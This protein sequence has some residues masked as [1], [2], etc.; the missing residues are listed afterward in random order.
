MIFTRTNRYTKITFENNENVAFIKKYEEKLGKFTGVREPGYEKSR[1][2]KSGYWDGYTLLYDKSNHRLPDGLFNQLIEFSESIKEQVEGYSYKIVDD[3]EELFMGEEDVPQ[4]MTFKDGDNEYTLFDYQ[5]NSVKSAI[6]SGKGILHLATN[7]GKCLTFN[8][9]LLTNKGLMKIGDIL[10]ANGSLGKGLEE[11]NNTDITLVNKYGELEKPAI[12]TNNGLKHTYRI[13]TNLGVEETSTD[14][15]P[16]LVMTPNGEKWKE[17]KDIV[18]GD[19][20]VSR[21]GDNVYGK[22]TS[23]SIDDSYLSGLLIADGYIS[24][25]NVAVFTN[26][27]KELIDYVHNKFKN[28]GNTRIEVRNDSNGTGVA[29]SDKKANIDLHDN[30]DLPYEKSVGKT[31]PN[32]ILQSP[33]DIQLAYLS[34]YIECEVSI[35]TD[36]LSLEISSASKEMLQ[37]VQLMLLNMGIVSN[38]SKK[39]VNKYQDS[40]YGRITTGADDSYILLNCLSFKTN[41]RIKQ[42]QLFNKN[43]NSR[44]RNSKTTHVPYGKE[45][46]DRY[47]K[48]YPIPE[49]G[50]M[51]KSMYVPKTISTSRFSKL[52]NKYPN[53]S[54]EMKSIM[55]FITDKHIVFSQVVDVEDSGYEKTY[56][57]HMPKTHSFLANGIINHNTGVSVSLIKTL[58]KYL[59][60]G[61]KVIYFVPSKAI[62]EQA[63]KTMQENFGNNAVGYIGDGKKKISAINVVIMLSMVSA[64]KD[65]TK[66]KDVKVTGKARTLQIFVDEVA[67][68]FDNSN[69][70]S[71]LS[72]LVKSYKPTTKSRT[73]ILEWIRKA[74][75][76][77]P[78]DNRVK[79]FINSKKAEYRKLMQGKV[80]TK[81][82][83]YED[84]LKLVSETKI[85]LVDE[86]H[87]SKSDT[88]FD[89]LLRFYNAP[90]MY[91]MTGSIDTKDKLSSQRLK[92]LYHK[93]IY[94]VSNDELIERGISAKPTINLIKVKGN[95]GVTS[96]E[97][98]NYMAVYEKG[99]V[100]FDVRNELIAG[101]TKKMVEKDKTS[102]LIV[103]RVE[104]GEILKEKFDSMGITSKFISGDTSTEDREV[105]KKEAKDGTLKVLIATSIFDEGVSI[106]NIDVLFMVSSTKSLRLILQRVGRVLRKKSGDNQALVFDF[107]DMTHIFL[108]N[109]AKDRIKI[110]KDQNFDIKYLN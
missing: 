26:D 75:E 6:G 56:D 48:T 67:P 36:K 72:N 3:R 107:V 30:L 19:W 59:E 90:Y 39:E 21:K 41:Q 13:T 38:L 93:V 51:K 95:I 9:L 60:R 103:N 108:K 47:K 101:L 52:Y 10:V 54:P 43:Y 104:H 109:H 15:H 32:K 76:E 73:E 46:M 49:D 68:L 29:L 86:G 2:Y 100:R 87:H 37:Q 96:E 24:K 64:L 63:I 50:N 14:N 80:G 22:N 5:Y 105:A 1:A 91:A 70:K 23:I 89:T 71:I 83:K 11:P 98:K 57:V 44:S 69:Q 28:V 4:D 62:F 17:A 18:V 42:V 25:K 35:D 88:T 81:Y 66:S 110:Y 31:V 78:T 53:G 94:T 102:L 34:G 61:E 82:K 58:S 40:W 7:A 65:P 55:G 85:V 8:N 16:I 27:Q 79:L 92:G 45:I 74:D 20:I 97:D 12:L 84:T 106:N 99:I 77:C 33:R